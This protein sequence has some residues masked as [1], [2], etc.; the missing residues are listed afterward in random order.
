MDKLKK[1]LD[2]LRAV[3]WVRQ[4]NA[5]I[6]PDRRA[7]LEGEQGALDWALAVLGSHDALERVRGSADDLKGDKRPAARG[8]L[9]A[10][11]KVER[12]LVCLA[13]T[14]DECAACRI[15]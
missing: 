15:L 12:A 14:G 10:L 2:E 13:E 3:A 9:R 5:R 7:E 11:R 6:P 8:A 1:K 4:L